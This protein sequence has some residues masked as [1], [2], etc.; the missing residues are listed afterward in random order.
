M[1]LSHRW[2][3]LSI[4]VHY[5]LSVLCV[6]TPL[7]CR[8]TKDP[9]SLGRPRRNV[10]STARRTTLRWVWPARIGLPQLVN[11]APQ[12]FACIVG[13]L[14]CCRRY[15][16][17]PSRRHYL[18]SGVI[19]YAPLY[20]AGRVLIGLHA[21]TMA[22]VRPFSSLGTLFDPRLRRC[23][24][25]IRDHWISWRCRSLNTAFSGWKE[26]MEARAAMMADRSVTMEVMTA[27]PSRVVVLGCSPDV[28]SNRREESTR[29]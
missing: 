4:P 28:R 10:E 12:G 2:A 11:H 1:A 15:H 20:D 16:R 21:S 29:R 23:L 14:L 26:N 18:H 5:T 8:L 9:Q 3:V 17:F 19:P 7:H 6:A 27:E 24:R 25:R 22:L 13:W